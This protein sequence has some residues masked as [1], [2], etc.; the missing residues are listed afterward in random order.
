MI[1]EWII[2]V[3]LLL[4]LL[5]G[6]ASSP[7]SPPPPATETKPIAAKKQQPAPQSP[8]R[9][10]DPIPNADQRQSS[11]E[12]TKTLVK[13]KTP[14]PEPNAGPDAV[15]VSPAMTA[16]PQASAPESTGIPRIIPPVASKP[17]PLTGSIVHPAVSPEPKGANR[18]APEREVTVAEPEL[19]KKQPE[20]TTLDESS[21]RQKSKE[22]LTVGPLDKSFTLPVPPET[23]ETATTEKR[24]KIP[25]EVGSGLQADTETQLASVPKEPEGDTI[26]VEMSSWIFDELH[27]PKNLPGGWVLDIRSDQLGGDRR[28]LLYSGKEPIFDG[29]DNSWIRLQITT[30]AVVVNANSNLDI[31]YPGQGLRVDNGDLMP[32]NSG[33][34]NKKTTYIKKANLAS[35]L[36]GRTCTVSLGFWPTWP[37]TSTQ[38]V[39]IDLAGFKHAYA[40][41]KA[42]SAAQ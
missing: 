35:M 20:T 13:G 3:A 28:C 19:A 5:S 8:L 36:E 34:L 42:C 22:A 40:A 24:D 27:L 18:P 16:D 11:I 12:V 33:L 25:T 32:F 21:A 7:K 1:I 17:E 37:V 39:S 15:E 31:S 41:L 29:Y 10:S 30:D 4:I 9:Q 14:L 38:Q 26:D 2:K 23:R 6:C